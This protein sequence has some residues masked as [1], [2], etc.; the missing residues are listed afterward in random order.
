MRTEWLQLQPIPE[1]KFIRVV[2]I[3]KLRLV[4]KVGNSKP[5]LEEMVKDIW[6][7]ASLFNRSNFISGHLAISKTLH[8]VQLLEGK[9]KVVKNLMKRIRK[10]PRVDIHEEFVNEQLSMEIGWSLL[11]CYSFEITSAQ[12]RLLQDNDISMQDMFDMMKNTHE[13]RREDVN[14]HAFYKEII[15]TMLLKFISIADKHMCRY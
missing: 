9:E 11:M 8:V 5:T 3:G 10:D 14:L 15:E 4:N 7:T 2:Y 12:L 1:S 6:E 13:V